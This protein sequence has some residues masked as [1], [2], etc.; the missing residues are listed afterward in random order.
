MKNFKLFAKRTGLFL[1]AAGLASTAN[2]QILRTS[3]T[4]DVPYA[5]QMN[6]A[7]MPSHGYL[8]PLIG[9][10]SVSA[11]SNAFGTGAVQDM[12][13]ANGDYYK[14]DKFLDNLP[15]HE[16]FPAKEI[17]LKVRAHTGILYKKI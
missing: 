4:Q 14:S 9:P 2:A 6:P 15:V 16:R 7:R 17:H 13:D 8:S 1:F 10:L 3:Y 5:L 12:M 11:S